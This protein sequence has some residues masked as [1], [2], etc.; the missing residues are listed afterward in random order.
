[1]ST[2]ASV[3]AGLNRD[4]ISPPPW[5]V[6]PWAKYQSVPVDG[7]HG[8]MLHPSGLCTDSDTAT[9][10]P[11]STTAAATRPVDPSWSAPTATWLSVGTVSDTLCA[12]AH[13]PGC[14][15]PAAR[16]ETAVNVP[17]TG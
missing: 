14:G 3:A 10:P 16:A 9:P 6:A 4:R 7:A 15:A 8:A 1:M 13:G 2:T 5:A 12:P 11:S 17:C